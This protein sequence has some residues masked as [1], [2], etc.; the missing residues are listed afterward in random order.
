MAVALGQWWSERHPLDRLPPGPK[1]QVG[2]VV[3]FEVP[4]PQH[5]PATSRILKSAHIFCHAI[6]RG[7]SSTTEFIADRPATFTLAFQLLRL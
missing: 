1:V 6:L 2:V 5:L 3:V 7:G 4:H